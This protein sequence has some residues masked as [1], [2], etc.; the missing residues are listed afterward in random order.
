MFSPPG[1]A[2]ASL[3][4]GPGGNHPAEVRR[5][6]R[7]SPHARVTVAREKHPERGDILNRIPKALFA[8]RDSW[9]V[10]AVPESRR[11]GD[12]KPDRH[13]HCWSGVGNVSI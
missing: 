8:G 1:L 2:G 7:F 9:K 12:I 5:T 10:P 4:L 3:R 6:H 13:G 11:W